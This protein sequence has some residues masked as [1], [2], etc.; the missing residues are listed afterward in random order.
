MRDVDDRDPEI[1][2]QRPQAAQHQRAQRR[3]DHRDRLVGDQQARLQQQRARDHQALAL[4]ARQLVR[5]AAERVGVVQPDPVRRPSRIISCA[6]RRD[7][8]RPNRRSGS[9]SAWSTL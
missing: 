6:S 9:D 3:I 8:A 5:K 1:L 2:V 7:F 4:A